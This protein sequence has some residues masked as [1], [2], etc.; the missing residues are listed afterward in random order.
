MNET[1]GKMYALATV[2]TVLA[3]IPVPLRFRA[4]ALKKQKVLIDD[5]LI[6]PA[7]VS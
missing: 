1:P 6:L 4:R 5:W 2:M 7:L 3:I